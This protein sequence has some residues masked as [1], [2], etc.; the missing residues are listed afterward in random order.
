MKYMLT[1]SRRLWLLFLLMIVGMVLAMFITYFLGRTGADEVAVLRIGSVV[2]QLF[3]FLLPAAI[4]ALMSTRLPA[5]MLGVRRFSS[6]RFTLLALLVF[7]V[8]MPAMNLL[9]EWF[10]SLPWPEKIKAAEETNALMVK[11]MIGSAGAAN[12]FLAFCVLALFPGFCEEMFFRGALQNLLRSRPMS[13]HL[14]IWLTALIF[15]LLHMQ[16]IGTVP[17]LL[18]GAGFGYV[19][20]WGRSLWPAI[21]CHILNNALVVITQQAGIEESVSR[22]ST[23]AVAAASAVLTAVGLYFLK[24]NQSKSISSG[25]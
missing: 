3:A 4:C 21:F 23:P 25:I 15:S 11:Q 20:W 17:R 8:S 22:L 12:S 16:P 10:E 13:P 9:I 2:Q 19:A 1:F 7:I 6:A 14:A 5:E 24:R 18:L